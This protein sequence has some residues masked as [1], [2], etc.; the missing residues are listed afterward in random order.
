MPHLPVK[1]LLDGETL[2]P[3]ASSKS[4]WL[5]S[6]AWQFPDFEN[7][8]TFVDRLVR[9]EVLVFDPVINAMLQEQPHDLSSRSVRHHFL[10]A[11][12]MSRMQIYQVERAQR[13]ADLLRQGIS[14]LDT[15]EEAGYFDQPH[16]TR[17]LKQWIGHTPAQIIR[18]SI[19]DSQSTEVSEFAPE[20][21][22]QMER[23]R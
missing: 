14:I 2:M 10:R 16:L 23:T 11:T 15:V 4:F 6:S 1:K 9:D 19:S 22:S 8:D 13:A 18:M 7:A 12:G 3:E 17:S 21:N 20:Y 5:K